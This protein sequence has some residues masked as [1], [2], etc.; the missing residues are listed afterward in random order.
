MRSSRI[1]INTLILIYSTVLRLSAQQEINYDFETWWGVMSSVQVSETWALWNDVHFVNDLFFIY[2]GGL[3]YHP[4]GGN[5]N[6]TFGYG[7]LRL[8]TPWS[9]G[10]LIRSEHR[11]WMQ[12]VYRLPSRDRWSGSFRFRFDSRF[13][14]DLGL[15][16]LKESYSVN[17]RFRFSNAIRYNWGQSSL[18][19]FTFSTAFLNESLFNRGPG[20]N[21]VRHEHRTHLLAQ[22]GFSD[23][24]IAT[25]YVMRY[26]NTSP[27]RANINHGPVFWLFINLNPQKGRKPDVLEYP[28]EHIH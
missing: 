8:T 5:F 15:E 19:N 12:T 6:T 10:D 18:G 9:E 27:E 13:I 1:F 24:T 26:I 16:D 20:P 3:T 25:G 7:H 4:K 21:G 23:F 22:W 2:R 11:P 28:S 17:Y 14:R